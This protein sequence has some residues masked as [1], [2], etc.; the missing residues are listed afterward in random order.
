MGSPGNFPEAL[1]QGFQA[2]H[3]QNVGCADHKQKGHQDQPNGYPGK[4]IYQDV[5]KTLPK[6]FCFYD[7]HGPLPGALSKPIIPAGAAPLWP[8][9]LLQYEKLVHQSA[10]SG[11][12]S[13]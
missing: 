13:A 9:S 2:L 12:I 6:G 5:H 7:A 10:F 4:I 8:L 1:G 11:K 3:D